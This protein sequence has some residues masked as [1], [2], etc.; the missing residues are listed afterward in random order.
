MA[1][2]KITTLDPAHKKAVQSLAFSADGKYLCTG[3]D[4]KT[5]R[6]WDAQKHTML[7][8]FSV[9]FV[10]TGIAFTADGGEV[11]SLGTRIRRKRRPGLGFAMEDD[12]F[13]SSGETELNIFS[14]QKD[15]DAAKEVGRDMDRHSKTF[16]GVV[17]DMV[18]DQVVIAGSQIWRVKADTG[19]IVQTLKTEELEPAWAV[20]FAGA[21]LVSGHADG[22]L[23]LWN[24]KSKSAKA[25]I[26]KS[27]AGAVTSLAWLPR[28]N[29]WYRRTRRELSASGIWR[30]AS[31]SV[32]YS[33][34]CH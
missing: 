8:Q 1:A 29:C 12:S 10:V 28:P 25:K 30:S 6:I 14:W 16:N 9:R 17:A 4:D 7:K 13:L 26:L 19:E 15:K 23:A 5:V 21:A 24:L 2:A 11:V 22:T 18:P 33:W 34:I 32:R 20:T 27:D 31:R 3:S